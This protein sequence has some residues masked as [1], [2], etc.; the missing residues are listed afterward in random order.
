MNTPR[1]I[2][3]ITGRKVEPGDLIILPKNS[4][5]AHA[6]VM[7]ITSSAIYLSRAIHFGGST[8]HLYRNNIRKHNDVQRIDAVP[9]V[10]IVEKNIE[11]PEKLKK[12]VR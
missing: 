11:I 10:Y 7:R 4:M 9:D 1:E 6:V 5:L 8:W 12:F 2:I 3:D